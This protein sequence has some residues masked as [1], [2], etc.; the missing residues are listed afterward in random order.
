MTDTSISMVFIKIT[1]IEST[2]NC[3]ISRGKWVYAQSPREEASLYATY[4]SLS[5][6][7]PSFEEI[8][9]TLLK[10]K[11]DLNVQDSSGQT[12]LHL[13][14]GLLG[15]T[16]HIEKLF[17]TAANDSE[18]E[19]ETVLKLLLKAKANVNAVDITKMTVLHIAVGKG[20]L[21]IVQ[22]LIETG[23]SN[24]NAVDGKG[25]TPLHWSCIK[26]GDNQL[27]MISYLIS[28]YILCL[29]SFYAT[30]V[31]AIAH[32][33]KR[34]DKNSKETTGIARYWWVA[35]VFAIIAVLIALFSA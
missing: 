3:A 6:Q 32:S 33:K 25:N 28:K 2:G 4:A 16:L 1:T 19:E 8:F 10:G 18:Y 13:A 20:N 30:N 11:P 31:A 14:T 34:V 22:L 5:Q 26:N 24:V 35:L 9:Q 12:V 29:T 21:E 23:R 7:P 15:N 17:R 27:E